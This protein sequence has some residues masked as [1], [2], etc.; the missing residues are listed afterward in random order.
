MLQVLLVHIEQKSTVLGFSFDDAKLDNFWDS[1]F[2][3]YFQQFVETKKRE[4]IRFSF[5][6]SLM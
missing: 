1:F 6:Y 3:I 2:P 4:P 5:F